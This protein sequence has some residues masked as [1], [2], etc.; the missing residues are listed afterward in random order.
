MA[1]SKGADKGWVC[2]KKFND[3]GDQMRTLQ[4]CCFMGSNMHIF[5]PNVEETGRAQ[6]NKR[7]KAKEGSNGRACCPKANVCVVSVCACACAGFL[8]P[9]FI[10][11]LRAPGKIDF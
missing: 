1:Y 6:C 3:N 9:K 10:S 8:P 7:G 4:M 5:C 11:E 2:C